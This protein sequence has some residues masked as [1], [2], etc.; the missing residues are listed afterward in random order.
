MLSDIKTEEDLIKELRT[1]SSF[2]EGENC[3]PMVRKAGWI[4]IIAFTTMPVLDLNI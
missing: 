2:L 3:A 4:I 1:H